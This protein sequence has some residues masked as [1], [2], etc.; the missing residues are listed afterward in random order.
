MIQA[1][2]KK[3][4]ALREALKNETENGIQEFVDQGFCRPRVLILCPFRGTAMKIIENIQK[5]LGENTSI[6]N[7]SKFAEEFGP[8]DSDS[9]DDSE[10]EDENVRNTETASE[11]SKKKSKKRKEGLEKPD[12][13]KALFKGAY[14][15][16]VP[17]KFQKNSLRFFSPYRV[18]GIVFSLFHVFL[19]VKF[20]NLYV[21]SY[22]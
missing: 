3:K 16:S 15:K 12:D 2:K 21:I 17:K 14:V 22:R 18:G 19:Y 20:C 4:K 11:K 13:W 9:D 7:Q 10:D 1:G 6:S 5:I 8:P